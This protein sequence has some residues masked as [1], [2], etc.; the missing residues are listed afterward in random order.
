MS[1]IRIVDVPPG[2]APEWVRKEWVGLEIP[3]ADNDPDPDDSFQ[4]GILG[5]ELKNLGGYTV[6]TK[7]A[8]EILERKSPAAAQW[9]KNYYNYTLGLVEWLVFSKEVCEVVSEKS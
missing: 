9:W 1:K 7:V 8:I 6:E 4:F 2:D 3:I 5:G